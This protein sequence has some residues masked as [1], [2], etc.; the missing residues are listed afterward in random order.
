[1]L[2]CSIQIAAILVWCI[3]LLVLIA[4]QP[5]RQAI[6]EL[7]CF[8][9]K[10]VANDMSAKYG[11]HATTFGMAGMDAVAVSIGVPQ[12]TASRNPHP[13]VGGRKVVEELSQPLELATTTTL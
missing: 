6:G 1:M 8:D 9:T 12:R 5:Q 11:G 7:A 4:K 2:I 13:L 10:S 3:G